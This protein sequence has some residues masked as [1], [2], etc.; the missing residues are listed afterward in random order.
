MLLALTV[1]YE[2]IA[3]TE[4]RRDAVNSERLNVIR[5][6]HTNAKLQ[7]SEGGSEQQWMAVCFAGVNRLCVG[8]AYGYV[9]LIQR[10]AL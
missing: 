10:N 1:R 8:S 3:F 6:T 5:I 9:S 4:I 7:V 2:L